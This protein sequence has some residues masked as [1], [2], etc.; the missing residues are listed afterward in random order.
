MG[1]GR[2]KVLHGEST[3]MVLMDSHKGDRRLWC[4]VK[5]GSADR[6]QGSVCLDNGGHS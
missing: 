4:L 3:K 2:R 1:H 6:H 5:A